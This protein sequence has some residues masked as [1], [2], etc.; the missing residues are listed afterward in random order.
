MSCRRPWQFYAD[1]VQSEKKCLSG[2]C[3]SIFINIFSEGGVMPK[4]PV[5]LPSLFVEA[6]VVDMYFI[7]CVKN[8]HNPDHPLKESN[9]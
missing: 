5:S 1:T 7:F 8:N 9:V 6:V 4:K 3:L 2:K